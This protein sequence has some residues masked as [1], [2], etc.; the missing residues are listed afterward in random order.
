MIVELC[1]NLSHT[2]EPYFCNILLLV[3]D[4]SH[5]FGH[6]SVR[7]RHLIGRAVIITTERTGSS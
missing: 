5:C 1:A 7:D 3:N 4:R 6:Q 2:V